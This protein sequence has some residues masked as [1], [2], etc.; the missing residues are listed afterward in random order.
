MTTTDAAALL[1]VTPRR[2]GQ[3]VAAGMLPA[4]D[5]G[6][7]RLIPAEAIE[8]RLSRRPRTGRPWGARTVWAA[9]W[10][11]DGREPGWLHERTL[12]RLRHA[13][14]DM[15]PEDLRGRVDAVVVRRE[16][17]ASPE[18]VASMQAEPGLVLG[19]A[20]ACRFRGRRRRGT[21]P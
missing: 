2:I 3:L 20:A 8:D 4:S 7:Q 21:G 15:S 9:V 12:R 18:A 5:G 6:G 16:W 19:G 11:A 10:L 13:V 14:A 1:G 17:S